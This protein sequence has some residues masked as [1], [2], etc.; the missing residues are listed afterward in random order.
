[1]YKSSFDYQGIRVQSSILFPL[2]VE[3]VAPGFRV[4]ST[5][6]QFFFPL[7]DIKNNRPTS[8]GLLSFKLDMFL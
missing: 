5:S 1:M 8:N 6:C 7:L 3:P 2:L 4:D